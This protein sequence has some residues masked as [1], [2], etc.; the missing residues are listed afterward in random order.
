MASNSTPETVG[1][2]EI[3]NFRTE[4]KQAL[5]WVIETHHTVVQGSHS[6]WKNESTPG[7]FEKINKKHG[8]IILN[9]GN[10]PS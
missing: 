6:T 2:F 4:L 7:N 5:V 9:L 8:K 10:F 3:G 1:D